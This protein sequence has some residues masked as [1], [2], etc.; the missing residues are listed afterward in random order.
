M[1]TA[2]VLYEQYKVLPPRIQRELK[3]M[4]VEEAKPTSTPN[5]DEDDDENGDTIRISM[6]ALKDS[7]REVKLLKAGK[8]KGRPIEELFAELEREE[9]KR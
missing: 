9:K 7:I 6:K 5:V 1:T 2:Q 4:I 3:Q 8:Q